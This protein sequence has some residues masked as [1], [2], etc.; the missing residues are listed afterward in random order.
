MG[1]VNYIVDCCG[2]VT[3]W[4][5]Y[6]SGVSGT[7]T[8]YFQVWRQTAGTTYKLVGQNVGTVCKCTIL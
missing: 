2:V 3:N 8:I 4:E 1:E 6:F 7:R 5:A